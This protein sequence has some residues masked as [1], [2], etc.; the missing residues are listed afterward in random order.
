MNQGN[1]K[2]LRSLKSGLQLKKMNCTFYFAVVA[3]AFREFLGWMHRVQ[4]DLMVF[5][6]QAVDGK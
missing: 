1:T 5:R 6:F 2:L 3:T 4:W